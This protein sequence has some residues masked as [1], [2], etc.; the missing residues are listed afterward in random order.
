MR[1][2]GAAI[3]TS[4]LSHQQSSSYTHNVTV[5]VI[6]ATHMSREQQQKQQNIL[7]PEIVEFPKTVTHAKKDFGL[8][9]QRKFDI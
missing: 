9:H 6:L 8:M 2:C 3:G 4:V 1:G 7:K 5:C